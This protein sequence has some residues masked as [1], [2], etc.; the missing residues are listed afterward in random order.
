M[1]I[2]NSVITQ[3]GVTP[4]GTLNITSNGTRDELIML[5]LMSLFQPL[6]LKVI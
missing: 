2:I 1:P 5:K 3:G 6:H 4:T